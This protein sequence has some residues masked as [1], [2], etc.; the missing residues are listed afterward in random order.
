MDIRHKL[1]F[2]GMNQQSFARSNP[3]SRTLREKIQ[4]NAHGL[5]WQIAQVITQIGPREI[6]TAPVE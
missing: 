2:L 5:A 1:N 4:K 3:K 6:G